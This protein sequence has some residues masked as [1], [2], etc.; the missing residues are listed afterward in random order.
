M[1]KKESEFNPGDW[2]VHA[3]HGLGQVTEV[4]TRTIEGQQVDCL[5]VQTS[6]LVYFMP[7]GDNGTHAIRP[8]SSRRNLRRALKNIR[9]DPQPINDDYRT[10]SKY[11]NQEITK[12]SLDDR[13]CL[14]RD[15]ASRRVHRSSDAWENSVLN[16]LKLQLVEMVHVCKLDRSA[17]EKELESALEESAS[18]EADGNT[19]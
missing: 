18:P 19:K 11:I 13:A 12:C 5:R 16:R 9:T 2:I 6:N 4:T 15:L 7:I 8:V 10:R 17:A 3:H 14:I 1:K